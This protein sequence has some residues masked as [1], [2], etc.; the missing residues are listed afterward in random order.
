M[1]LHDACL[2]DRPG[3]WNILVKNGRIIS[4][5]EGNVHD[6]EE[7]VH[8]DANGCLAI[9]GF[10]NAHDHLDF[11]VFPQ[12]GAGHYHN[13]REWGPRVQKENQELVKKVLQIP[14][15][16]RTRWGMYKNLLNGFTTVIN[17]G[18][19]L[20]IEDPLVDVFQE[21]E[22][23]HSPG[24]EKKW[25]RKLN[26]PFK[27]KIP[28]V[29]HAGEGI[30]ETASGELGSL[31]KF[32]F[33]KR[34]VIV[35]HGVAMNTRQAENFKGLVWCPASNMFLF[36]KTAD[37]PQLLDKTTVVFGTDSTLTSSWN[38][39]EQF[40]LALKTAM[41]P[42]SELLNMLGTNAVK[43]FGLKDKGVIREGSWADLFLIK[44]DKDIFENNPEDIQ[45]VIKKGE[46]LVAD[47]CYAPGLVQSNYS[48]I[49]YGSGLKY[50]FGKLEDL[51]GEI[52]KHYPE[53]SI[54]FTIV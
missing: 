36:G 26:N 29:I 31:L 37:V 34:Q 48:R 8:W 3:S 41:I 4:I 11:N 27:L 42:S 32:N 17:H 46:V 21:Y 25:K 14:Q 1:I 43:L 53:A 47:P 44:N 18:A 22:S 12:L 38:A 5:Y 19:T 16:I 40:R 39:W 15:S 45:M 9:P 13:Y 35:V 23:L 28:V 49:S 6:P 30:D 24:F 20:K 10:I 7:K 50:V 2:V 52:K 54:P 51:T 33:F